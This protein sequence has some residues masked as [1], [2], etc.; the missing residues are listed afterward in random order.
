MNYTIVALTRAE[1]DFDAEKFLDGI[2][3]EPLTGSGSGEVESPQDDN[4]TTQEPSQSYP[5]IK[6]F[7]IDDIDSRV[8]GVNNVLRSQYKR[9]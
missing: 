8:I 3:E 2:E 1:S 6:K 4:G 7:L 5:L 9:T